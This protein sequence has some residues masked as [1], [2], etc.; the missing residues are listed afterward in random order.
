MTAER[1]LIAAVIEGARRD[2]ALIARRLPR[3][4]RTARR[5]EAERRRIVAFA[6]GPA[7]VPWTLAWCCA[8]LDLAYRPIA[9][10]I[11]AVLDGKVSPRLIEIPGC[12]SGA[13]KIVDAA[14]QREANAMRGREAWRRKRASRRS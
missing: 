9:K 13:R 7:D 1:L 4:G 2:A 5:L 10:H 6:A 11:L 14:G 3:G 12:L 8:W